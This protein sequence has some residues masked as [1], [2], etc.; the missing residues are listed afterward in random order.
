MVVVV[1]GF[2]VASVV[3]C[4]LA[5]LEPAFPSPDG[6]GCAAGTKIGRPTLVYMFPPPPPPPPPPPA[7]GSVVVVVVVLLAVL[8][9]VLTWLACDA[10]GLLVGELL[11]ALLLLLEL[12][13]K[14]LLLVLAM[15][16]D[17]LLVSMLLE[18]LDS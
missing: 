15:E 3:D 17:E 11:S 1:V 18:L 2:V 5:W 9:L 13:L 14:A 16:L 8:A 12:L 10:K 4:P 6:L 7:G